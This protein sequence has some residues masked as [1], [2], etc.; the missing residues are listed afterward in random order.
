MD[1]LNII[2][3][4]VANVI[5]MVKQAASVCIPRV[6]YRLAHTSGDLGGGGVNMV[7]G[8]YGDYGAYILS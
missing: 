4:F 5:E 1:L 6:G 8:D 3:N 2:T 7:Y